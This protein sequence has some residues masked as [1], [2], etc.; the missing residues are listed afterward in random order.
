VDTEIC[1]ACGQ[2]LNIGC[3]P[4]VNRGDHVE[5]EALLCVGCDYCVE[6]CPKHAIVSRRADEEGGA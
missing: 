6:V 4:I 1:D 2:C 5:I 3:A